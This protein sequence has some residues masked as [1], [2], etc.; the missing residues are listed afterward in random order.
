[1][2]EEFK[3]KHRRVQMH[4]SASRGKQGYLMVSE[5]MKHS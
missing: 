2:D 4:L 3:A 5:G 1:M